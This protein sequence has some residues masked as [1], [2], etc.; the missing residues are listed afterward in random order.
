MKDDDV[1]R[2]FAELLSHEWQNYAHYPTLHHLA[3]ASGLSAE[4]ISRYLDGDQAPSLAAAV[5]LAQALKLSLDEV[6]ERVPNP[7]QTLDAIQLLV[8][9]AIETSE[10]APNFTEIGRLC[11]VS[12]DTASRVCRKLQALGWVEIGSL[13][14]GYEVY[15][16]KKWTESA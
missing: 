3:A 9:S 11:A 12:S 1:T 4:T 10:S 15:L 2:V 7:R 8:L 14:V 13:G 6:V 16:T 5:R